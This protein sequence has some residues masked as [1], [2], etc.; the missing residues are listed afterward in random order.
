MPGYSPGAKFN[1]TQGLGKPYEKPRDLLYN[2]D[3]TLG[4]YNGPERT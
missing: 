4:V 3:V 1:K 2:V